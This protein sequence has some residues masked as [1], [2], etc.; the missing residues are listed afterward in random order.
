MPGSLGGVP[1]GVPNWQLKRRK[2]ADCFHAAAADDDAAA[3]ADDDDDDD[4][5]NQFP[6]QK[7]SFFVWLNLATLSMETSLSTNLEGT[8]S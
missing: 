5:A 4:D 1:P 3:A 2:E 8:L 6:F 7:N